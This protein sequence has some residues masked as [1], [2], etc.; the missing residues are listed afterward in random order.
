MQTIYI[1]GFILMDSQRKLFFH[2]FVLAGIALSPLYGVLSL[3][4]SFFWVHNTE[5]IDFIVLISMLSFVF[6][7]V[8][9]F[10]LVLF[11]NLFNRLRILVLTISLTFL[12]TLVVLPYVKKVVSEGLVGPI[13]IALFIGIILAFVYQKYSALKLFLNYI[14][15][16]ILV[17]PILFIFVP[18]ILVLIFP[19]DDE[20]NYPKISIPSNIPV[21]FILF[22]EF[23]L[24][25]LLNE[26][27]KVDGVSFPNFSRLADNSNW[28][29]NASA[30]NAWTGH[31]AMS[32]LTGVPKKN[33]LN[34]TYRHTPNNLFT[35][36]GHDYQVEAYESALRLCPPTICLVEGESM[37][38]E[39]L[40]TFWKDIWA[41]YLNLIFP[42]PESFGVPSITSR[43]IDFW[44]PRNKRNNEV[45]GERSLL[46]NKINIPLFEPDYEG[47]EEVFKGFI[48][49]ID[50]S[51]RKRFYFLHILLP[52]MP[53]SFL[54]TGKKYDITGEFDHIGL[55][56]KRPGK[57][58]WGA[59]NWL[60]KIQYQKFLHQLGFTDYWLGKILDRLE[61]KKLFDPAL[62]VVTADHG[63]NIRENEFRRQVDHTSVSDI[64]SIPLFVK[65]PGQEKGKVSDLPATLLDIFPT[66]AETLKAQVPWQMTGHSLF[67]FPSNQRKRVIYDYGL[68]AYPVP[69]DLRPYLFAEVKRQQQIFGEFISWEKLR[70]RGVTDDKLLDKA[71]TDMPVQSIEEVRVKL[72]SGVFVESNKEILPVLVHGELM[73]IQDKDGW[74]VVITVNGIF[75]AESPIIENGKKKKFI[76][77]LPEQAFKEGRNEVG[78]Y[79]VKKPIKELV[80]IF[81]PLLLDK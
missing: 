12:T 20:I 15:P 10:G 22:D 2:F 58:A 33:T 60:V 48:E 74:Q 11:V 35:F 16:A 27:L 31:A 41:V 5:P 70:L 50:A 32:L 28:F 67:D 39:E 66:L 36:L 59:D 4:P 64:A 79:L 34:G 57:E 3:E 43:Y 47:R 8:I 45:K 61:E 63:V 56:D 19:K 68:K 71:V 29:R 25:P 37:K 18:Q 49:K 17:F 55:A 38:M 14:S 69:D 78:A 73:G 6:P 65:L 23:P 81:K 51:P 75:Q 44:G 1:Y 7:F 52:H 80:Q 40:I 54:N 53:Y 30:N 62:V 77:F 46:G 9:A 26:D 21:V 72:D 13:F 42:Q 76:A 24:H